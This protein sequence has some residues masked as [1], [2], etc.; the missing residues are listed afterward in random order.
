[1]STDNMQTE[2]PTIVVNIHTGEDFDVFI[3]RP[4][5]WGNP[6]VIGKDGTR[7]E[8]VSKYRKYLRASPKLMAQL[9]TLCGKRLGCYCKPASCHGDVLAELADAPQLKGQHATN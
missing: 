5:I 8:V 4:S 3:G 6:F 2:H 1:M 9:E 7:D